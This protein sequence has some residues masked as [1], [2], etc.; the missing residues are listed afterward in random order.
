[1]QIIVTN[2][3]QSADF[4]H[5]VGPLEVGR[6]PG[7]G[8]PRFVVEDAYVSRDQLRLEP[9]EHNRVRIVNLG[10]PIT[11]ST[12]SAPA[13]FHAE[14]TA[15]RHSQELTAGQSV[16]S[17][18]PVR[19]TA[20]YTTIELKPSQPPD[21][22]L[23][24]ASLQT[25]SRPILASR[26]DVE[27]QQSLSALGDAPST[28]VLA[29]WLERLLQVQ[30]S[31][32]GSSQFYDDTARAVVDLI[33]LDRGL[34]LLR[35]DGEPPW[36][37]VARH[38]RRESQGPEFSRK[39]LQQVLDQKRTFFQGLKRGDRL[40]SLAGIEAVVASP[41][42]DDQQEIIGVVYGSRDLESTS[43]SRGVKP[44]EAQVVQLLAA[45]VS[46][47]LG[48]LQREADAA[49]MRVTFEQFFSRELA[50]ALERDPHMLEGQQT[51]VTALFCDVRRF[52]RISEQLGP[53]Q[54]Y[55]ML[56]DIMD[57]LTDRVM[58]EGGVVI[59]YHGDGMAAMWNA[60]EPQVEHALMACR[61]AWS[62]QDAMEQVNR[63][64]HSVLGFPVEIGI[65]LNTGPAQVGNAG[66][67]LRLKYG[68]LGHTVNLASRI[69]GATKQFGVKVLITEHVAGRLPEGWTTRRLCRVRVVGIHG[70][71]G[72]FEL[73]PAPPDDDWLQLRDEYQQALEQFE[74]R[75]WDQAEAQ[76]TEL[77][78]KPLG[79]QDKAARVMLETLRHRSFDRESAEPVV[80][81][82]AK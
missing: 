56:Q 53:A 6:G 49:R 78:A 65:G 25:L 20:G 8:S 69:E 1:M 75:Q 70:D 81:L 15:A 40:N 4:E 82:T 24:A 31:A 33:G 36:E 37:I 54:T 79:S 9:L 60:P 39:V 67:S 55:R 61:A 64:W 3:Q 16:E 80:Q 47:G 21:G 26:V 5:G 13:P 34:V 58:A 41:V 77:S 71:V 66:S 76:F 18:L 68:P 43:G 62:M 14:Q 32:A 45:A 63:V 52:S 72:I 38:V 7:S 12:Q 74:A 73:Q 42:F 2:E 51:E 46:S 10:A 59:D 30:K 29:Q 28:E 44:L 17:P 35:R 50:R 19:I 11:L 23:P 48:R 27:S 22:G 57:V